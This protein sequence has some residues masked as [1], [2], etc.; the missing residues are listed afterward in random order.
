MLPVTTNEAAAD[1]V[2]EAVGVMIG[3]AV[4]DN[5][6]LMGAGLDSLGATE[7]V[8]TLSNKFSTEIVSTALFDHPTTS[9]LEKYLGA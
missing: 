2:H 1:V 4:P 9:S 3:T 6:P 8:S 5:A 7:L